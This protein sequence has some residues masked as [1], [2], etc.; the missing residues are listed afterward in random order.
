MHT[1]TSAA[2]SLEGYA[3]GGAAGNANEM[4]TVVSLGMAQS[5]SSA[6]GRAC[7]RERKRVGGNGIF[8]C[9][10][11]KKRKRVLAKIAKEKEQAKVERGSDLTA[12][13]GDSAKDAQLRLEKQQPRCDN[14][15]SDSISILNERVGYILGTLHEMWI[16]YMHQL[17]SPIKESAADATETTSMNTSTK[18]QSPK[19]S[20]DL[21]QQ[22]SVTLAAAE[23]VGMPATIVQCP[24]RLHLVNV[25]C[26]VVN[27][28]KE[29]WNIAITKKK[30]SSK[31]GKTN[32]EE[33]ASA[34][35]TSWKFVMVPKRGTAMEVDLAWGVPSACACITVRLET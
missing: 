23:H 10:S 27:E 12:H 16:G 26:V 13:D 22:I 17:I 19:I 32:K 24:S 9:V 31:N 20:V 4:S 25:R 2:K 35:S 6:G 7:K 28:T 5:A 8:G 29:T 15:R 1:Y 3:D 21:R 30:G 14:L 34:P 11:N 18:S 33:A